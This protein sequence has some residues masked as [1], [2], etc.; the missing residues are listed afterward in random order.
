MQDDSFVRR[1]LSFQSYQ[2]KLLA[3]LVGLLI[4]LM[5][6]VP[7]CSESKP[8]TGALIQASKARAEL[9]QAIQKSVVH[10]KVEQELINVI[11]SF[12]N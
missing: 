3:L 1:K 6:S 11:S 9:E 8:L 10:I 5:A 12:Q 7:A 4:V 2:L